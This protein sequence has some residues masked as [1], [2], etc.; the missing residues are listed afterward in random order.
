MVREFP[1]IF[2]EITLLRVMRISHESLQLCFYCLGCRFSIRFFVS[3]CF[4]GCVYSIKD[5]IQRLQFFSQIV[6]LQSILFFSVM[7]LQSNSSRACNAW[8]LFPIPRL[9]L[10]AF[11]S[12]RCFFSVASAILLSRVIS[13]LHNA[14]ISSL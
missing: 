6:L 1:S 7:L 13:A 5:T 3:S 12:D 4:P 2:L 14:R 9:Y 11:N 10:C 8:N